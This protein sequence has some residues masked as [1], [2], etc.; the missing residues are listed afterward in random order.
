MAIHTRIGARR[1]ATSGGRRHDENKGFFAPKVR[2]GNG[3]SFSAESP[4][5]T[6]IARSVGMVIE[7]IVIPSASSDSYMRANLRLPEGLEVTNIS[8]YSDNGFSSISP[9]TNIDAEIKEGRQ[10]LGFTTRCKD[11]LSSEVKEEL[12]LINYDDMPFEKHNFM[13]D[14]EEEMIISATNLD[15]D[16]FTLLMEDGGCDPNDDLAPRSE[17]FCVYLFLKLLLGSTQIVPALSNMH[18]E[19]HQHPKKYPNTTTIRNGTVRVTWN[20]WCDYFR[21][22]NFLGYFR[23]GR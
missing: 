13:K 23:L 9:S 8:F 5:W 20:W 2:T 4:F 3:E 6:L 17:F 11:E 7:I 19:N 15:R 14:S 21:R 1:G 16:C 10:S 18:R 22:I 12:W